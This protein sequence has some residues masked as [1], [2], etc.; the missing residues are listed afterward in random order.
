MD[1]F[2]NTLVP[3]GILCYEVRL[4]VRLISRQSIA[5]I[6]L[7]CKAFTGTIILP[8]FEIS[9]KGEQVCINFT[10]FE[11]FSIVNELSFY[12]KNGTIIMTEKSSPS[13][14][15]NTISRVLNSTQI[16]SVRLHSVLGM[17]S[18][19]DHDN[20]VEHNLCTC[21]QLILGSNQTGI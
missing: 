8:N 15:C 9:S 1:H 14:T 17:S 20:T 2:V 12:D 10:H 6:N 7:I 11:K 13:K 5:D 16:M 21:L 18:D 19:N 3:Q 4:L